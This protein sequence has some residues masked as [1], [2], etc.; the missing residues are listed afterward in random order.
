MASTITVGILRALLTADTA[1]FEGGVRKAAQALKGFERDASKFGQAATRLGS[2]LTAAVTLP[3]VAIGGAAAKAAIEF[4]SSFAGVRKTVNAT[5]AEFAAMAQSFRDLSKQIPVN[6]NDLNRLGEAAGA[7]GIPKQEIVSFAKVMAELGVTTNVTAD[8]AAES[9]AKIQ[10]IF[11]ASGKATENFASTLV[12]LGNKGA[13]TEQEILEL[14]KRVASAGNTIGL[15]QA[16]VLGFSSAIANVGMEA[17]AGGSAMSRVFTDLASAVSAGGDDLAA[18]AK[19]AGMSGEAFAKLFKQDAATAVTAFIGGLG[20]IKASGGDLIGTLG[21]LGFKE[22]R[23]ADL[24]RRLAGASGM[25]GESLQTANAAWQQNS[26][27]SEEAGKRF[28]TTE[29]RITLLWNRLKDVAITIGNALLP[30]INTLIGVLDTALPVIEGI[31]NG[32]AALPGPVQL[33]IVGIAALVA[34]IGPLLI[35]VGQMAL[36]L[37]ALAGVGGFAGLTTMVTSFAGSVTGLLMPALTALLP[38]WG[39]IVAAGGALVTFLTTTL[40]AAFG[41]VIAF[42]GPQG[43]IAVAV[44]AAAG[45][46]YLFGDKITAVVQKVYTAVKTWLLD[47]FTAVVASIRAKVEAV[48]GFFA[49]MYDKVVGHSYV[50]DMVEGIGDEFGRL[51]GL[52]VGP[53][54]RSTSLVQSLFDGMRSAVLDTVSGLLR[55][56]SAALTGWLDRFM[57]SWAA[58]LLGGIASNV[59]GAVSSRLTQ[60]IPGLGGAGGSGLLSGLMGGGGSG[61]GGLLGGGASIGAQSVAAGNAAIAGAGGA[62]AAGGLGSTIAGL[63]TNPITI[64]VAGAALLTYAIWKKGLFRGGWEGIEGNQKRDQFI[65]QFGGITALGNALLQKFQS[66]GVPYPE[67]EARRQSLIDGML[68]KANS[69]DKFNAAQQAIASALA[70]RPVQTFHTGGPVAGLGERLAMLLGGE[71]VLSRAGMMNLGG[72][73]M[74]NAFNSGQLSFAGAA[75]ALDGGLMGGSDGSASDG[76]RHVVVNQYVTIEGMLDPSTARKFN[77]EYL[78]PLQK[79]ALLL[80]TDGY[81]TAH[82]RAMEQR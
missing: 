15:S 48:T 17:E 71:G 63:A 67:A 28:A 11:G 26:A 37:S 24:L 9:I 68:L 65:G 38:T 82:K 23:Q 20:Q 57:P 1:Q 50:P 30:M 81:A 13:S 32:F 73:G 74:L 18:F 44:L 47:K 45:I 19:V 62:G 29:A 7:L 22:L 46:W 36:G 80:N 76:G 4:E 70:P 56:L 79:E 72:A 5:E 31:A 78:V 35:L 10:N 39:G 43:L 53:A 40:P 75:G 34:A 33:F 64:G 55:D 25:V 66:Q 6:V 41:T 3:I 27:L 54:R 52:M 14:A 49:T 58:N 60:L 21:E 2:T 42:L 51:D 16:Q 61:L 12:D 77:A 8:Q 69:R 59:M